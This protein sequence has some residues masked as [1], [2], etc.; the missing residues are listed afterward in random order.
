MTRTL[1][2]TETRS[3]RN[4]LLA[5][6][7]LWL[8]ACGGSEPETARATAATPPEPPAQVI[9]A[10]GLPARPAT[11]S[12]PRAARFEEAEAAYREGRFGEARTLFASQV[13]TTPD[14]AIGHYMLGLAAWKSGDL[15]GAEAA[16]ARAVQLDSTHVKSR[17]NLARVLMD[18]GRDSE[19]IEQVGAALDLDSTS[20]EGFRLL[21]RA[22][23]RLGDVEAALDTYRH[24]LI[25]NDRDG[26]AMNNLGVLYLEEGDPEAALPPLAR[27]VELRGTSPVFQ[28]NLGIALERAG[29]P[30]AARLAFEAALQA[31]SGYARARTS[32]A[33]VTRTLEAATT[34]PVAASLRELAD[35]FRH[36]IQMWRET[37][38]RTAGSPPVAPLPADTL[39]AVPADTVP[40]AGDSA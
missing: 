34:P 37:A 25:T 30:G 33:R 24:A 13:A 1:A 6:L 27:A 2:A 38:A 39:P 16:L 31:D 14:R 23:H 32:L 4:A 35:L 26:W 3:G 36:H 5:I 19:A 11:E 18:L 12:G 22:Q 8:A 28:H 10:G 40:P 20:A 9:P 15:A 17:L 29:F 7:P 21:A